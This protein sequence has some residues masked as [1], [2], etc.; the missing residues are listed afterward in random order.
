[1]NV[2]YEKSAKSTDEWFT[3]KWIID[4]IIND[5]PS[6]GFDLDPCT[7]KNP[8]FEIAKSI[9]TKEDDGLQCDWFG[10]VFMNPPYSH[11]LVDGFIR[12]LARHG[13]GIALIFSRCDTKLFHE[14]VFNSANGIFFL[15]GRINFC[16]SNGVPGGTAG[17]GSVLVSY[18]KTCTSWLM[19][20]GLEGKFLLLNNF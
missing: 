1:M 12:K 4:G 6:R 11:P 20:C 19:D 8:P 17:A 5:N 7:V 14:C 15:K 10:H 16:H 9:L 3:P 13:D 18:G 2:S